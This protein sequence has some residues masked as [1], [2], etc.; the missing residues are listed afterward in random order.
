MNF[1]LLSKTLSSAIRNIMVPPWKTEIIAW[2]NKNEN[3]LAQIYS[4]KPFQKAWQ[5]AIESP[6]IE[7][8]VL[9]KSARV[10]YAIFVNTA[11]A[12]VITNDPGNIM[13]AQNTEGDAEKFAVREAGKV[14]AHC[15]PVIRRMQGKSTPKEKSFFG[16]EL[17]IVWA[18]SASSFRM[19]TIKYL[20][21]DEV[22]GW[23]DNVEKEG[24]PV[25]L[26]IT[27]TET[28][29][30]RKIVL[31]STPK[32]AGTCKIT[33]EF[34][35]TDQ[36][37]FHVPCPH[38]DHKQRLK[39]ENFRY[40]PDDLS[41]AHFVCEGC[42]E[43]IYEHHK[44]KIVKAGEWRATREFT[45]CNTH[46]EPSQWDETG[47]AIC[48]KCG[49]PGDRNERGKIDAGFHIWSAYNDNPNTALPSLASEYEKARKEPQ[50]MQTFMNTK[51]GVEYSDVRST[52][53]L[54]SF[55]TIYTRC[56]HYSPLDYLPEE[57]L[58]VLASVDTQT[59]RFEYHFW[60]VG[61]QGEIWAIDYGTVQGDPEDELTQKTLVERLSKP[62]M[63]KDGRQISSLAV[64]MDCNDHAWKAMLEF[65]APYKGWIYAI[66]GEV[67]SKSKFKPELTLT[68]KV[69]PEVK[70]EYR[71][72][73]VHQLKNRAA[74]R[75]NI[76]K[77]GKNYIHFPVSDVFDL[78]YFQML[79]AEQLVGSGIKAAWKKKPGQ[80]RNE[81]WDL[82]V[83]VLWLYDFL[84]PVIRE[85]THRTPLGL[86]EGSTQ[87][88]S[89]EDEPA[90][91]DCYELS[92]YEAY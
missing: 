25:E 24:D 15:N 56:D 5:Q 2:T 12:W 66:R 35:L 14:F 13:I 68:F 51:V 87:N 26:A 62:F 37:F 91:S 39:L 44:C 20:F 57:T 84:R 53:R 58:C 11:M 90:Y 30:Q 48:C 75:L 8:I 42:G 40:D 7:K 89:A 86:L 17:C 21:M 36:R 43:S 67:N 6:C 49:K 79:T 92:D 19:L 60:A 70:C 59:Y 85:A 4:P 9:C 63:L 23:Q 16:G 61:A 18:T 22:S 47:S 28:E 74:E 80:N 34:G 45:C 46:Q 65:C 71:S 33:R 38:C 77:P 88:M 81:P 3:P 10:G 64:V 82:L 31:G 52:H 50:K 27:R 76:E 1:N 83:Y 69:H 54:S 55:E 73:N 29:A 41:T 72:L 32:A 78:T